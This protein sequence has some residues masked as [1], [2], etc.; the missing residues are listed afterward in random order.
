MKS[1]RSP[2]LQ[3]LA[4]RNGGWGLDLVL[5]EME[6]HLYPCYSECHSGICGLGKRHPLGDLLPL[7]D[8]LN[9]NLYLNK[10]PRCAVLVCSGRHNKIHSLGGLNNTNVF[11]LTVLEDGNP[12]SGCQR[13]QVLQTGLFLACRRLCPH[14]WRVDGKRERERE[15]ERE[16]GRE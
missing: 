3:G 7:P 14:M 4:G 6:S 2:I 5:C 1:E 12:R 11:S 16:R 8:L 9:Q 15:R 10:I 13:G